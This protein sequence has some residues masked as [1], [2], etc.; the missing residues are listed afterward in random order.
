MKIRFYFDQNG[1]LT[2]KFGIKASSAMVLQEGLRTKIVE[3]E[4]K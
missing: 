3:I 2:G 4:L 1:E